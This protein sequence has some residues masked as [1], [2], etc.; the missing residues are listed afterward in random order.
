MQQNLS[1][2][3]VANASV[4]DR[5]EFIWKC[6][7]H[8]VGGILA[9][10]AV[11]AYLVQ[12]GVAA[13]LFNAMMGNWWIALGGFVLVSWGA[14]HVAHTIESKPAQYAAFAAL[15]VAEAVIFSPLILIALQ[16]PGVLDSAIGVTVLGSVGLIATAMVSTTS[17][18]K[19]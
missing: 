17:C 1:Y 11:L 12:S 5:S 6:Y 19:R 4:E 14:S 18:S 8:V 9:F 15:V 2:S 13:S 7:A 16:T 3:A 10:A